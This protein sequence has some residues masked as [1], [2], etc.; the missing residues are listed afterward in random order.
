MNFLQDYFVIYNYKLIIRKREVINPIPDS[1]IPVD[2]CQ[3]NEPV[4]NFTTDDTR[5]K[6]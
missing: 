6:F 4:I 5:S 2:L 3:N 1:M